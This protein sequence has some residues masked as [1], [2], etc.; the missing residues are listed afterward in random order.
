MSFCWH[1]CSGISHE[2]ALFCISSRW[3]ACPWYLL[4]DFYASEKQATKSSDPF[5]SNLVY[6]CVHREGICESFKAVFKHAEKLVCEYRFN[7][8]PHLSLLPIPECQIIACRFERHSAWIH[9][10]PFRSC[11]CSFGRYYDKDTW[12]WHHKASN[13]QAGREMVWIMIEIW[14]LLGSLSSS[15]LFKSSE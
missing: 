5:K 2:I 14:L 8:L 12:W 1:F 10:V 15:T 7:F 11:E 3:F 9:S 13:K 6:L 4:K